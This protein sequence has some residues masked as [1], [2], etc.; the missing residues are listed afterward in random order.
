MVQ[1]RSQSKRK[2]VKVHDV[3][4][5]TKSTGE[6][7]KEIKAVII[8]DTPTIIDLDTK[9][10]LDTQSQGDNVTKTPNNLVKL[11]TKGTMYPNPIARPPPKPPELTDKA[12]CIGQNA[13]ANPNVDFEENSSHQEG[14]ISEM[15][16]SPEQS[17]FK[18]PQEL[19]DL[20]DTS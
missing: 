13:Y 12:T 5:S 19:I 8:D 15:Y 3:H 7:R 14:I 4:S 16:I 1:T 18:K 17:Y 2:N 10:G 6:T 9:S 20:V 11:G